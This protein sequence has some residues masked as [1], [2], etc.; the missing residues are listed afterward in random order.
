MI[1]LKNVLKLF[2]VS[3]TLSP[4]DD[5]FSVAVFRLTARYTLVMTGVL[6][7]FSI[8]VYVLF[9]RA[10]GPEPIEDGVLSEVG[11]LHY[12]AIEH[13]F[14]IILYTDVVCFFITIVLSYFLAKRTL[15]PLAES[16]AQQKQFV[17]DTA[18]ELRTPLAVMKAGHE[19]LL[20]KDRSVAEYIVGIKSALEEINRLVTL[21]NQLLFLA[22]SAETPV[23]S[24]VCM[25]S[26]VVTV[27]VTLLQNYAVSK[28]ITLSADITPAIVVQ[29]Q[30]DAYGQ[31]VMNLIKNAIDY[32]EPTGTVRVTLYPSGTG[33]MLTVTDTGIG[34]PADKLSYIFERFYKV[35]T[36][37]TS[38]ASSGSGLGLAIVKDIVTKKNG[39]ISVESVVGKGTTMTV[40]FPIL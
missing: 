22:R 29:G 3:A 2:G 28:Q 33:C 39:T 9:R 4:S 14:S 6:T 16:Y 19:V 1:L 8:A 15:A 30:A 21:T 20:Q 7:M 34:I 26:E 32:T 17:A 36:A 12:D 18:H 31:V 24:G 11:H 38:S 13:L 5:H 35:D 27:N 10:L 37:R 40:Q 25:L 23:D